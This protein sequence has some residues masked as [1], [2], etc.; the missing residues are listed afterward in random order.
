MAIPVHIK[1][2]FE[3][4]LKA[5]R[6]DDLALLECH[7]AKTGEPRYVLAAVSQNPV[8]KQYDMSPFGHLA[9]G[10]PFNDYTAPH[11]V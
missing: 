9:A 6:N 1:T 7:D 11:K 3:T 4:L 2:N 8:T 10:N 5:A